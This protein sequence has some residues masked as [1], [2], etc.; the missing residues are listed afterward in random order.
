M[1]SRSIGDLLPIM[2]DLELPEGNSPIELP[3]TPEFDLGGLRVKP[4][5]LKVLKD[6]ELRDLQPRMMQVLIALAAARPKVVSRDRLIARCWDGRVVGDDALNR[7]I[8]LLRHLSDEFTPRPFM[9]ETVPRVGYRLVA[10]KDPTNRRRRFSKVHWLTGAALLATALTAMSL[11]LYQQL[12]GPADPPTV[13][14]TATANDPASR[15]LSDD[16]AVKLGSIRSAGTTSLRL[17]NMPQASSTRPDLILTIAR[18]GTSEAVRA[19]ATLR[20]A[21]GTILLSK[22]FEQPSGSL[23]DLRQQVAFTVVRVLDCASEALEQKGSRRLRQEIIKHYLNGCAG[24][25]EMEG[26][27]SAAVIPSFQ[28]VLKNSPR[29]EAAWAMLL[30]ARTDVYVARPTAIEQ[31]LLRNDLSA[32]KKVNPNLPEVYAADIALLSDH[33]YIDKIQLANRAVELNP[34]SAVALAA[35][36]QLF[37]FVGR[38]RDGVVDARRAMQREPLSP[39]ARNNYFYALVYAGLHDAAVRELV[40]SER[41]WPGATSVA[42]ARFAFNLRY[43]NARQALDY[44]RLN[45]SA[46]WMN[47]R[48]YLEA[49]TEPTPE[50]VARA[51]R[52]AQMLYKRTPNAIQHLIQV[53]TEFDRDDE[54]L[55]LLSTAPQAVVEHVVLTFRPTGFEFW[56]DPRALAVARRAGLLDYWRESGQWPDFCF[57]IDLPYDCEEEAAKLTDKPPR[58]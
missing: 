40:E 14:I 44:L 6:G 2:G 1:R 54:L 32:A 37:Q 21:D 7:V 13:L 43:G 39:A 51:I 18:V 10:Q 49:R 4:S 25:A 20:A 8:L 17:I 31:N 58:T 57:R 45:P 3:R 5:E 19:H 53:Y 15:A 26:Q 48:S 16:V 28:Y 55:T 52:D 27:E 56:R 42:A 30:Q 50:N 33:A 22:E 23:A 11:I 34:D 47:A 24:L 29:F 35:R 41:I 36:S 12:H 9:I 38:M 46:D